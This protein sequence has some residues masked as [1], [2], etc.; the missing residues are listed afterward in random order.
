MPVVRAVP[1]SFDA[2]IAVLVAG[3]G[4]CGMTA[5]IAAA[6][7]GAGVVVLER[8]AVPTGST[9][10]AQGFICAAGTRTQLQAG[11]EDT[12]ELL[13]ADILEKTRGQTDPVLARTIA[14]GAGAA[15]DWLA[16][17]HAVPFTV[18][19]DW[20]AHFGHSRSRLH[21]V[22]GRNGVE[23]LTYLQQA[24]ERAGAAVMTSA[25]V[26]V[27]YA[28]ADGRVVGVGVDRPDG[29]R[30]TIGCKA[31][32]L[33]TCGFGGN[34]EMVR[35]HIPQMAEAPY[36]GHAGNQGEG[37]A[38]GLALGAGVA[39]MGAYQGYGALAEPYGVIF[40]YN[41]VMEGAILV[42]ALGARFSDELADISGQAVQVCAQPGN[43]AWAVY[44]ERLHRF[45]L[46]LREYQ[47]L[48]ELGAVRSA[49][50]IAALSETI[51]VPR[52]AIE[53]TLGE[54]AAAQAGLHADRFGR[55]FTACPPL[56][57]PYRAVRVKGALFH[58][59][60]GLLVDAQARVCRQDGS[61]LPNLFA[62]GGAARSISGPGVWGYLPAAGLCMAVTLGR[63][64]GAGAARHSSC[65]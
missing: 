10:M 16:E 12:P 29:R 8:D 39:D 51:K 19:P 7:Q 53:A 24:A 32:V 47:Q 43:L 36:F 37:I 15:I 25:H 57:A 50:T 46:H 14:Y 30:E 23:L 3:G 65:A 21:G 28:D 9:G 11:I 61:A 45:G 22:P 64:A 34:P 27:L 60:G 42:N 49:P 41:I 6:E 58:T 59:Q 18:D 5:A 17:D 62:G 44:D 2:E 38:W 35:S 1:R 52:S 20:R 26:A 48:I 56:Q 4:A 55:D 40:N 33:A 63:L 13:L 31:L 54:L